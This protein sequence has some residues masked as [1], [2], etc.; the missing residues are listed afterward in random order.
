[1]SPQSIWLWRPVGLT[2]YQNCKAVENWPMTL[3]RLILVDSTAQGSSAEAALWKVSRL[4][5]G[6]KN[7]LLIL[8]S[9]FERQ[10]P[11]GILSSNRSRQMPSSCPPTP[12]LK[13]VEATIF[14][15]SFLP[16]RC[17][18]YAV[19]TG[20]IFILALWL[21]K[22]FRC[23]LFKNCFSFFFSLFSFSRGAIFPLP[24]C[25]AWEWQCSQRELVHIISYHILT[26][27]ITINC[28]K[29]WKR[30][31]YQ[32]TWLPLEKPICRSGSNS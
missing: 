31:E 5:L 32:T 9:W 21:T 11:A 12:L 20:T 14:F 2:I 13:L 15:F 25:H 23:H 7:H 24:F 1:M 22:T 10:G 18:P 27:W 8:T 3:K 6:K 16:N 30:W 29:F 19:A 17:H 26:V 28:G 4:F